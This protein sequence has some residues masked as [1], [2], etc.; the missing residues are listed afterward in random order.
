MPTGHDFTGQ[1]TE[2]RHSA[3]GGHITMSI[4]LMRRTEDAEPEGAILTMVVDAEGTEVANFALTPG[5]FG[6]LMDCTMAV[7]EALQEQASSED[8]TL[9]EAVAEATG[10]PERPAPVMSAEQVAK[11]IAGALNFSAR[12]ASAP[13]FEDI[14]HGPRRDEVSLT[15]ALPGLP[16]YRMKVEE[17]VDGEDG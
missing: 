8:P 11:T 10:K 3:S 15:V 6:T 12:Q 4:G 9:G 17:V 16:R 14:I 2:T 13:V 5:S 1:I 7:F